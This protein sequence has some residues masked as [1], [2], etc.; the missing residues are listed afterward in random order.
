MTNRILAELSANSDRK[1]LVQLTPNGP[2]L[3]QGDGTSI[4]ALE[5]HEVDE[6]TWNKLMDL[7]QTGQLD[8]AKVKSIIKAKQ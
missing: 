2:I 4:N 1:R 5:T 6:P 3:L 8:N 7:L